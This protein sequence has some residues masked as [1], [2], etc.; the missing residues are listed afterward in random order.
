MTV[1][2]LSVLI[3][4][5]VG[6][7]ARLIQGALAKA[8][9]DAEIV[10]SVEDAIAMASQQDIG[11]LL[12]TE[13]IL[14]PALVE[15]LSKVLGTQETWSDLPVLIL[16][17]GGSATTISRRREQDRLALGSV[18][19]LERPIRI[20]TLIS[21]V[22]SALRS[23]SRQYQV[24]DTLLERDAAQEALR[25]SESRLRLAIESANLGSWELN[26]DDGSLQ[27][28]ETCRSSLDLPAD[29]PLS[30]DHWLARIHQEDRGRVE[31]EIAEAL[32]LRAPY[33][34]EFRVVWRDRSVH[35]ISASARVLDLHENASIAFPVRGVARPA[36]LLGVIL[37]I[38]DRI[39]SI[40]ALRKADKLAVVGRFAS[41]IAHE[42]NNPLES[43][44]NLLYLLTNAEMGP[45]EKSYV[46]TAQEELARV[47]AI[48]AQTLSFNRKVEHTAAVLSEIADSVLTLYR[49]R[50]TTSAIR[51]D[52][53]YT[54]R[55][56]V[57]CNAGEMRQVLTNLVGNAFDATRQG[58]RIIVRE[59]KATHPVSG[60]PGVR[61][62]VGD[63][64]HGISIENRARI[65]DAFHSTKGN[66]GT[67][68]GLWITKEIVERHGGSIR[69]SSSTAP[70]RSGT[71]F[72]MF[73]PCKAVGGQ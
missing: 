28:S 42:I 32:Q 55:Q 51:V 3:V 29:R 31:G 48:V 17:V 19:L 21:S 12:M 50:L 25:E 45:I 27:V 44:T 34:S 9:M 39:R 65:F 53:Q 49:G 10:P 63:T 1:H 15:K 13:E 72:S 7:D 73:I 61:F 2:G 24:R 11:V 60:K 8:K 40:E 66:N 54:F 71:V 35:W 37:D 69:F 57:L 36:R 43:V 33:A 59:R 56:P 16:T 47:S 14:H 41:S 70:T 26:V 5:P 23:R 68:L 58:G 4:A 30:L 64:G 62:T 52:R 67:G 46:A 20:G 6:Q 18:T 22:S 38:T